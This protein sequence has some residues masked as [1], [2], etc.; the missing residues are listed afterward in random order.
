MARHRDDE[1]VVVV[2]QGGSVVVPFLWGLA[3]GAAAALLLAPTSGEELRGS[4]RSRARRLKDLAVD[5]AED[6]EEEVGE[7]YERARAKVEE[8]LDAAR[9]YVGDTRETARDVVRA[10]KAAAST[11]RD[12]LERRLS[13]AREARRA[14][15]QAPPSDE[16]P[17]A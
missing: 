14:G 6:F 15:R 5:K 17:G 11:A 2:Q 16:E 13:A 1:E 7:R 12:E 9:R 4:L 8:E 3:V 10:G